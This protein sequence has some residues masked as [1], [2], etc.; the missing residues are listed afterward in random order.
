MLRQSEEFQTRARQV[1]ISIMVAMAIAFLYLVFQATQFDDL[2]EI[3]ALD[4]AQVARNIARGEGF[5][6]K[7]VRPLSL[8]VNERTKSID[9][10][11]ELTMAPLQPLVISGFFKTFGPHARVVAW[12]CGLFFLLTVGLTYWFALKVSNARVAILAMALVATNVTILRYAISGLETLLLTFLF[13]AL[14]FL[15]YLHWAS[16]DLRLLWSGLAGLVVG[17][18]YLTEYAWVII[19]LPA[20]AV[21]FFNS[22]EKRLLPNLGVFVALSV[23]VAMPW[24]V[25]NANITGNPF[26]SFR[27]TESV[28]GTLQHSGNTLYRTWDTAPPGFVGFVIEEPRQTYQKVRSS[29]LGVWP[30]IADTPGPFLWGFFLAAILFPFAGLYPSGGTGFERVRKFTYVAMF[31]ILVVFAF[32]GTAARTLVPFVPI[33]TIIGLALFCQLLTRRIAGVESERVERR[34]NTVGVGAIVLV[35]VMPLLLVMVTAFPRPV[36]TGRPFMRAANELNSLVAEGRP[37]VTDIP[38]VIAWYADRPAVYL[39]LRPVDMRRIEN[40]V[41]RIEKLVL[42]PS[43]VRVAEKERAKSWARA[44]NRA[45]RE[46]VR[47]DTWVVDTRLANAMWVV[48]RRTPQ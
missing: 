44:W 8:A 32:L 20:L 45:L 28:M 21:I 11:P 6:T 16:R 43:L 33:I 25:R 14:L 2:V 42:T 3:R 17:L 41:G 4:M 36:T 19:W 46:D 10:H 24:F 40:E 39:P 30:T 9:H 5:T 7:L 29:L 22:R 1:G 13:T 31:L 37:V 23:L 47:Y 12:E 35:H 27:W 48:F 18:I 38:W 15:L 26:F 34:W